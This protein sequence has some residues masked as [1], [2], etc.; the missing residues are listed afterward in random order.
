MASWLL[1]V[2]KVTSHMPCCAGM[3]V[4]MTYG[5]LL[6]ST[7]GASCP[8]LAYETTI[9]VAAGHTLKG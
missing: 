2:L 5:M 8:L 9:Y 3:S 4:L 6:H 1:K 7:V